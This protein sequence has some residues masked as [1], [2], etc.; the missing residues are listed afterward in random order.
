MYRSIMPCNIPNRAH[1]RVL[2]HK[3]L[4]E[5]TDKKIVDLERGFVL[6][7]LLLC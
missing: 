1:G 3:W 7:S 2:L 5:G 4:I 6:G